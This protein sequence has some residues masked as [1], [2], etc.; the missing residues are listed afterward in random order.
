MSRK[1]IGITV[2]TPI[3]PASLERKLNPVKSINGVGADEN[4]NVEIDVKDGYT[5]IKGKDYFDG[6]NGTSCTHSWNG[7]VLTITS[8]SGTSSAD[9]KYTL[10][11]ADKN[12]IVDAVIASLTNANGV[13]F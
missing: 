7:T 13:S 2:G 5:P 3:S 4:G 8:A 9:L 10:T 11:D 12:T 6:K 1:I